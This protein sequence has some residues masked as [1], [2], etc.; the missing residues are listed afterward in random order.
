MCF[1]SSVLWWVES[2]GVRGRALCPRAAGQAEVRNRFPNK[3]RFHNALCCK[4]NR[5]FAFTM[6]ERCRCVTDCLVPRIAV[7]FRRVG[8]AAYWAFHPK[9]IPR[10][11]E[12]TSD[13][14][15][16]LD[17][18]TGAL[19]RLAGAGR[20]LP[21]PQ[22]LIVPERAPGAEESPTGWSNRQDWP[23]GCQTGVSC[24]ACTPATNLGH[25]DPVEADWNDPVPTEH[26]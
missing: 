25:G 13:M 22:M 16:M 5:L 23:D 6:C 20:L 9:P 26:P 11:L 15:G 17:R 21:D 18:A 2:E 12:F 24:F 1:K 7:R 14:V 19:H 8:L 4:S 10:A 3:V